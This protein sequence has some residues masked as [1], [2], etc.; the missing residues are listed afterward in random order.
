MKGFLNE[1]GDFL[2]KYKVMGIAGDSCCL[3]PGIYLCSLVQSLVDDPII[4]TLQ[5]AT[6]AGKV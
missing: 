1:F 5:F 4:T 2:P 6:P 3:Y